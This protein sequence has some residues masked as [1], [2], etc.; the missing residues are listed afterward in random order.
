MQVEIIV[1]IIGGVAVVTA[2]IINAIS[3]RLKSRDNSNKS[4]H[5][6]SVSADRDIRDST[7][8]QNSEFRK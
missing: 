4:K 5:G 2:A 8:I 3:R 6:N 7:I 1:A